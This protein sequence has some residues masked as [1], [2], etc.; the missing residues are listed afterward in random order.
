MSQQN[1]SHAS[2]NTPRSFYQFC[3]N[4]KTLT[5]FGILIIKH[6]PKFTG[7]QSVKELIRFLLRLSKPSPW[8]AFSHRKTNSPTCDWQSAKSILSKYCFWFFGKPNHSIRKNTSRCQQKSMKSDECWV[9]GTGNWQ[10]K[11]PLESERRK[12]RELREDK[13]ARGHSN[14][15]R[16]CTNSHTAYR[17]CNWDTGHTDSRCHSER[18]CKMPPMPPPIEYSLGW[19][20]FGIAI[21]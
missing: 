4:S 18:M 17:H 16:G 7:T 5:F 19:I 3:I 20:V 13:Q 1:V 14:H 6:F 21:P 11:T 2:Y 10:N 15:C 9:G 12:W 8:Q